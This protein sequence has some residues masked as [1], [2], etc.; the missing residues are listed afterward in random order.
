MRELPNRGK[1]A[2]I[3]ANSRWIKNND[4]NV[5]RRLAFH[6]PKRGPRKYRNRIGATTIEEKFGPDCAAAAELDTSRPALYEL[7]ESSASRA[8]N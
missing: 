4:W 3:M 6:F 7:M 8:N 2:V 5:F 1:R